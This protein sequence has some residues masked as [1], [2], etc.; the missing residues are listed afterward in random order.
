M[1]DIYKACVEN[2]REIKRQRKNLK[3]LFNNSI[4]SKNHQ[5]FE[6]LTKLYALLYSSFAEV[7]FTKTIHTPY[8]ISNDEIH[9][10]QTQRNLDQ[11]W[12]KCFELAFS[13]IDNMANKGEIQNKKQLLGRHL[14]TYIVGPSQIRNK[15]AHGQWVIALNND[16]TA[17]NLETTNRIKELDFVKI[18]ILFEVYEKIGQAVEDLIESPYKAHFRDFYF[19]MT[20]LDELISE[21]KK[22]NFDTKVKS[23]TTKFSEQKN[24]KVKKCDHA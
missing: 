15:I 11:K 17:T 4:K 22:W 1:L 18:D 19:H 6:L 14:E 21:T 13:R 12:L 16:N 23:L 20:E 5:S 10:I 8:G 3:R 7:C 24:T 9:Q 2:L